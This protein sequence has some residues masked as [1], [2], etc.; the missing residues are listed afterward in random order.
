M[1]EISRIRHADSAEKRHPFYR[2][3]AERWLEE[4]L[5]CNIERLDPGLRTEYVYSQVPAFSREG[6][7][8]IDMLGVQRDGRLVVIE[9][10]VGRDP[11]F[12]MQ[13]LDYWDRVTH[14][15]AEGEFQRRGFFA[16]ANLSKGKPLL[17]LIAPVFCFDRRLPAQARLLDPSIEIY[18]IDV[19]GTWRRELRVV[20][21]KLLMCSD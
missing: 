19:A 3:Q 14:L 12:L 7:A 2:W 17:Y 4:A 6:R 20:N 11:D 5:L 9:L 10:K 1:E 16:G 21:K 13:A 15:N 18:R 8:V